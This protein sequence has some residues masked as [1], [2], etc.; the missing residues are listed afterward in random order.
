MN[1][2]R[3]NSQ[4]LR[5]ICFNRSLSRYVSFF[6]QHLIAIESEHLLF[7]LGKSSLLPALLIAEGYEK[8]IVTQPRRLPCTSICQRVNQTMMVDKDGIP[9]A[10][11]A[12]SGADRN[13]KAPILYL[14][15]GLLKE[16][17]LHDE[18]L[19]SKQ[20]NTNS[21]AVIFFL[22]EVHERSVNIDLCLALFARLLTEKPDVRSKIKIII[23]SATLDASVPALFRKIPQLKFDTFAMEKL[24]TLFPVTKIARPNQNIL[25]LV[26]ELCKKKK[27]H[28]QILCFVSSVSEVR[29]CCSLLEEISRGTLT[30]FPLIQSQSAGEQQEYIEQG[31]I[32][33]STTVAETS[34]TFPALT[35]C[36]DTG[37]INI[38]VYD[39]EKKQ[40]VLTEIRAAEST[41]KQ[42]LGRLG[43]TKPGEYYSL[44]DFKVEDKRFPTAQICQSDLINVEFSLRKS[45]IKQGLNYMTKY[46]PD[47]PNAASMKSATQELKSLGNL[48]YFK[49][50]IKL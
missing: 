39:C 27:R 15:D 21:K 17:L 36:I 25:D 26:Q 32:F 42:R 8:V 7:I 50:R 16:R 24:G 11:W 28:D 13:V 12:V 2:T 9:L 34:L 1:V 30:A 18:Q 19:I 46:L 22:D 44:Y 40:T 45:I 48:Y 43:R 14:T 41:I 5:V 3:R 20:S 47:P 38:P 49:T 37:M 35:Y 4:N 6:F 29:Q 31:S 33:F 10:G 23:S